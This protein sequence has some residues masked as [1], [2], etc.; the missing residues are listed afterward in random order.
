MLVEVLVGVRV[1]AVE[2]GGSGMLVDGTSLDAVTDAIANL[3]RDP[4]RRAAMGR[5]G[6]AWA[7]RFRWEAQA[8]R[9]RSL[10]SGDGDADTAAATG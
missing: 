5:R 3:V 2:D 10:A 6:P 1:D 8:S 9:V 4:V 7:R